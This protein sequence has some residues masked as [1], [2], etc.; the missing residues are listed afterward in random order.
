MP[1]LSLKEEILQRARDLGFDDCRVAPARTPPH[2]PEFEKWLAAGNAGEMGWLERNKQRRLDPALVLP[3]VRTVLMLAMNYFQGEAPPTEGR[4]A[5]YAWGDD[6]HDM[7]LE[8]LERLSL[9]L[10]SRQGTQKCYVDTGPV[11][12]RDYAALSGLGWQGKSTMVLNSKLGTW[13]FLGTILTTLEFPADPPQ[14]NRCGSCTR[15]MAACPTQAIGDGLQLDARLCIS[16]LTIELKG[17]IPVELRPLVGAR[18]YGCDECLDVC[19]WNRFAKA[20]RESTFQLRPAAAAMRLQDYL[21]LDDDGFRALFHGSPIKRIKRRGLLRNV[22]VALGNI[23]T[24]EALPALERATRDKEP[25]IV[26][27]AEWAI[28]QISLRHGLPNYNLA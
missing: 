10:E 25:L 23:G 28:E 16:Y 3:G 26:E 7:M 17:S 6:Y 2:G 1:P 15:C 20:S 5:R 24:P 12:E 18:I 11:L 4:I 27:H 22:C 8:R 19:P 13:F 21:E 9:F 14:P